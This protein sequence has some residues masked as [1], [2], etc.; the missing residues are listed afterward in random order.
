VAPGTNLVISY[1]TPTVDQNAWIGIYVPG[2]PAGQVLPACARVASGASGTVA[3]N[4]GS[5]DGP[6]PYDVYYGYGYGSTY[7]Q[8][9][10]P[11]QLT[12][13]GARSTLSESAATVTQGAN[14][15][16]SYTTP[17]PNYNNWVGIYPYGQPANFG[18]WKSYQWAV[19]SAGSVSFNAGSLSPGRYYVYLN[20]DDSYTVLTGPLT[21][22]VTSPTVDSGAWSGYVVKNQDSSQ[23]TATFT[24]PAVTCQSGENGPGS[25]FWVG[26]QSTDSS[27]SATLVMAGINVSCTSGQP[28]YGAW[29]V[30]SADN[31]VLDPLPNAVHPGDQ[32]TATVDNQNNTGQ[33]VMTVTDHTQDWSQS[34]VVTGG[35][36]STDYGAVAATSYNGGAFFSPMAVTGATVNGAPLAQFHPEADQEQTSFYQGT[37]G[38]D[39]GPLDASGEDFSFFWTS[40]PGEAP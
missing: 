6:G 40:P 39:P 32:V 22:T 28:G 8:L 3:C 5:L 36:D 31:P 10:G 24:V 4:T 26:I 18:Q 37:A 2:Q 27:G 23:V 17:S 20:Y 16:F 35:N 25:A 29:M 12:V 30:P 38:L 19:G 15:R 21:L 13:T 7:H 1:S 33:Y 9:A 34:K 11:L 14:V